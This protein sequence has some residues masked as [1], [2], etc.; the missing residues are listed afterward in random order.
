M[1]TGL[2]VIDSRILSTITVLYIILYATVTLAEIQCYY[3]DGFTIAPV[4]IPC[5]SS[6]LGTPKWALACCRSDP[7]A[8]YI[9]NS[10]CYNNRVLSRESCTDETWGSHDY[11]Q[12]CT[13]SWF[14]LLLLEPSD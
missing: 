2:A 1:V 4:H 12:I 11:A 8:Y 7:N 14:T 9:S 6:A 3:P 13:K 10:L 5:D